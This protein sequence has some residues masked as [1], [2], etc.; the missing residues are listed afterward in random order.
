MKEDFSYNLEWTIEPSIL[1]NGIIELTTR[2]I[3]GRLTKDI[4]NTKEEMIRQ[5]LTQLGWL[6]PED[7]VKLHKQ[8]DIAENWIEPHLIE[9]YYRQCEE[10]I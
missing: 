8:L 1:N 5:G 2:D 6:P 7:V 9:P 10:E 4:L 3:V